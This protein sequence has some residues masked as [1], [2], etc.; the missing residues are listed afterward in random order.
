MKRFTESF[1]NCDCCMVEADLME[2]RTMPK[3]APLSI[4]RSVIPSTNSMSVKPEEIRPARLC[5]A[6]LSVN[7][8][9][10]NFIWFLLKMKAPLP[11][12]L[13]PLFR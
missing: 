2:T 12:F 11:K 5:D 6:S 4:V 1:S 7:L 10:E 3:T 13:F 9:A 8:A